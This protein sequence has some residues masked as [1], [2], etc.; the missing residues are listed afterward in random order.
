MELRSKLD[1]SSNQITEL[2]DAQQRQIEMID[3]VARQRDMY[4]VLLAQAGHNMGNIRAFI[5]DVCLCARKQIIIAKTSLNTK[6]D[7]IEKLSK[8]L[9]FPSSALCARV[10]R[11]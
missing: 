10:L 8:T 3:A 11:A 6:T 9:L 7:K 5:H 4:R 2:K 1:A